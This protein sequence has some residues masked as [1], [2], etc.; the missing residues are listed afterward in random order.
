MA[1]IFLLS[2]I[3]GPTIDYIGLGREAYHI[4][5]HF[6]LFFMLCLSFYKPTKSIPIS[7]ALTVLYGVLDEFHQSFILYRSSSFFDVVVDSF[8]AV[9]A[10][11]VLWRYSHILPK[12]LKSLLGV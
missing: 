2:S 7:I 12:K 10:A 4:N 5:G 9:L 6:I 8:G 11:L 1:S 3:S